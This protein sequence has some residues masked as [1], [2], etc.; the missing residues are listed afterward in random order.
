[1]LTSSIT[2]ASPP[3]LF[4]CWHYG[5]LCAGI[6]TLVE[7]ALLTLLRWCCPCLRRSLPCRP[8]LS[9][10]QLNKGE[11]ARKLTAQ[12]K[13][14]KGKEACA[15]GAIM[16]V[17]QGQQCQCD[18]GNNT[19]ATAQTCQ[20]DGGNN[21]GVMTVMTPMRHEGKDVSAMRTTMQGQRGQYN[22]VQSWQ[23]CQRNKDNNAI[24]TVAKMPVHQQWW[25]HHCDKCE[26][27]SLKTSLMPLQQGQ[28]QYFD[29]GKDAWTAKMPVHQWLQHNCNESNDPSLTTAKMPAHWWQQQPHCPLLR[30]QQ[31]QLNDSEKIWRGRNMAHV[32]HLSSWP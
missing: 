16:P 17:H 28:Q 31:H 1:M 24:V 3:S 23:W 18:K 10:C 6:A 4:L 21:T 32:A 14:N 25:W 30:G 9:A 13:H 5:P 11:D 20:V 8:W 26:D 7:L 12:C 22:T 2:L 19:S 29:N 15:I 27:T